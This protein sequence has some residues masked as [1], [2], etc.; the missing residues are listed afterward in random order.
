[1]IVLYVQAKYVY[2]GV[3]KLSLDTIKLKY[4]ILSLVYVYILI[5]SKCWY[6]FVLAILNIFL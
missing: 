2:N 6:D 5:V 1:M 4:C 3:T